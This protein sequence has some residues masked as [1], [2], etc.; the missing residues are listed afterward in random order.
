MK[1]SPSAW[2]GSHPGTKSPLGRRV[3][4]VID[5]ELAGWDVEHVIDDAFRYQVKQ[6]VSYRRARVRRSG[7]PELV[8]SVTLPGVY[9][10]SSKNDIDLDPESI[11]LIHDLINDHIARQESN[12]RR[13]RSPKVSS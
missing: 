5:S 1:L 4:A 10:V 11:A 6:A 2:T 8:R 9:P 3:D 13:S 7:R 12:T